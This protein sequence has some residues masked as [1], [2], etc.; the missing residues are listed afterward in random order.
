MRMLLVGLLVT[1]VTSTQAAAKA[2]RPNIVV[3]LVDDMGFSD[4][5]CYGGEIET[6]NI[7]RLAARGMR[8]TQFYNAGRC[9]P[10]RASLLTG[11]HPHQ[12]G[13]GHMTEPPQQP[14][15]FSGP[16]QGHLNDQ[17]VTVA[18]VLRGAGYHTLMAGK[19]HVGYH[20]KKD[21]PLQRGFDRYYG[22]LAGACNYF[23]P[24][25]D[26]GITLGNDPVE[27]EE[28]FYATDA[29]TDRACQFVR[30]AAEKDEQPFFLYLAYNAPHWPLNSKWQEF[31][32]YKGKYTKGWSELMTTRLAK[33]QS[34]GMFAKDLVPAPHVGPKW[35]SL[36]KKKRED[37]DSI[38]AAYAGCIDSIDQNVGKLTRQLE[39]LG[40]LD[41]TLILF[42]SDNGACQE[43]GRL[44]KGSLEMVKNPPL[45]TTDGVRLG[46][47]WANA[48]NTP[49]RLYKHFVHEGGACTPMIASWPKGI[50][51]T[52][53]GS[54]VREFAY[55]PDFM[56]T[57]LDLSGATYPKDVPAC[58]GV[59]M[60]QVLAGKGG[61]IH[62]EPIFW[63][64][65]GNAGVRSGKW[66]LVREYNKPWEL[67][68]LAQDR[69][70]MNN[71]A[72]RES[73]KR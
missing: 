33:Q 9:C 27:T 31:E 28:D 24:G 8:F 21:W 37:L 3:I 46:L 62:R 68:D 15:G 66:K 30:E 35:Q 29:F 67:Y 36:S 61:P 14:L 60:A 12:V 64:H 71:L 55:L 41:D 2:P 26:R 48:C 49:F 72:M 25:G 44:G 69:T 40:K 70:E 58:E 20:Q 43:G 22:C 13:I 56:A 19:W 18:E 7:D 65:E 5:G 34:L 16:Y 4:I 53:E 1:G 10:T 51:R 11:R 54:F 6:P 73:G 47:A 17:C 23:R 52:A 42:L 45:E 57:F 63:E 38:M 50:P 32:K 39:D 59:S